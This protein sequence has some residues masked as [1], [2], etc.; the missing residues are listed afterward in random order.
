MNPL[1]QYAALAAIGAGAVLVIAHYAKKGA[2]AAVHVAETKLNPYSDKNALYD[3]VIGG[4]GQAI[5]G[6]KN[7]SLGTWL[8]E[9]TH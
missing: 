5:S 8:Y 4:A 9:S 7:W 2:A 1:K 6:D 3:N